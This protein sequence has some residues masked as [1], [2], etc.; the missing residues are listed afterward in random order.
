MAQAGKNVPQEADSKQ[1]L[2]ILWSRAQHRQ[3]ANDGWDPAPKYKF[4]SKRA[5]GQICWQYPTHYTLRVSD[6]RGQEQHD[7]WQQYYWLVSV[8]LGAKSSMISGNNIIGYSLS[9]QR[10]SV[11]I[12]VKF[13]LCRNVSK[14]KDMKFQTTQF[15]IR[16]PNHISILSIPRILDF[17][18]THRQ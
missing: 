15:L 12:F 9:I 16:N 2:Q 3:Y 13:L 17:V 6:F 18:S 14:I 8:T 5:E 1:T 4:I 10:K 7:F 11:Q